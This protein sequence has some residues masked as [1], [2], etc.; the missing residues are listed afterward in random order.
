MQDIFTS[1]ALAHTF[2]ER[3][4]SSNSSVTISYV[5]DIHTYVYIRI[6]DYYKMNRLLKDKIW[7]FY[8]EIEP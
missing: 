5:V 6:K 8:I 4:H 1:D 7:L 2:H 3:L